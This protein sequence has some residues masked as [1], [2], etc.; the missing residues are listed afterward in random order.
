MALPERHASRRARIAHAYNT[1]NEQ[2]YFTDRIGGNDAYL[3]SLMAHYVP[4]DASSILEVG[5]ATGLWMRRVL[6][7]RPALR[8]VTVVEISDAAEEC[9][10]RLAPLL[11]RRPGARLDVVQDDFLEAAA[12]LRPAQVVASSFVADYM[13][14]PSDYLRRLHDLAEPG[15][16]VI[17][18]EVLTSSRAPVGSVSPGMLAGSFLRLCLAHAKV[19]KLPPVRGVVR[20]MGLYRL[21]EEPAFKDL[22]RYT[23]DYTFPRGLWRAQARKYPG[24]VFHDLGIVGMLVLP[25]L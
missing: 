21:P 24:A 4:R 25:K 19:R 15:G 22:Q 18:V 16:R 2:G 1:L 14:N 6:H 10:R 11:D 8:E 20:S 23:A 7:K 13:G 3:G 17:A 5:A 9:R 12:R